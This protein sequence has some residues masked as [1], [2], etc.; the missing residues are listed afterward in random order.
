ML[1]KEV[2]KIRKSYIKMVTSPK[3]SQ[4]PKT[5]TQ[6]MISWIEIS[7][8]ID[9]AEV[10]QDANA[11]YDTLRKSVLGRDYLKEQDNAK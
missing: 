3:F 9:S 7:V 6:A 10:V 5:Q 4:P 8:A 2:E 11:A 1:S